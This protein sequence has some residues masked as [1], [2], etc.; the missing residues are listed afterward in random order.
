MIVRSLKWVG[1][2]GVWRCFL[3][4]EGVIYL[5]GSRG[6]E[7]RDGLVLGVNMFWG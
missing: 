2:F 5:E 6:S 1:G 3:G 7:G 4:L